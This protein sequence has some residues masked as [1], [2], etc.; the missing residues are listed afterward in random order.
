MSNGKGDLA[1]IVAGYPKEMKVFIDA[2]PGLKSRFK[3][4][5]EFPD[6]LPQELMRIVEYIIR[7]KNWILQMVPEKNRRNHCRSLSQQKLKFWQCPICQ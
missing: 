1:V 6:Y 5:F 3:H 2:N 7:D 4:Y